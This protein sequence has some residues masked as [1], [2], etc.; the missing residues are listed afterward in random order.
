[1]R[2]TALTDH[3]T[4]IPAFT[5]GVFR[6]DPGHGV[7]LL[8]GQCDSCER[9]YFPRPAVC[10][11]CLGPVAE[12][13]LGS[14]GTLYSFTV[15]RIKPPLGLPQPYA[16]AYIDLD[17]H[18]LRIFTLLDPTRIGDYRI[19][20]R[21]ELTAGVIGLDHSGGPCLRPYF[22]PQAIGVAE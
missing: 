17:H 6:S 5:P 18:A 16:V 20:Q 12:V 3:P 19:G 10:T 7:V 14:T 11:A 22:K 4:E 15:V 1:V 8:G 9:Y 21:L 2:E 13:E